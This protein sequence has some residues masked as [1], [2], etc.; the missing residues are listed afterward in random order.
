MWLMVVV[1]MFL[2]NQVNG[3]N[4]IGIST[5]SNQINEPDKRGS[6]R[7]G[8]DLYIR[9]DFA[10]GDPNVYTVLVGGKPCQIVHF[11]SD[12]SSIHCKVPESDLDFPSKS[13]IQVKSTLESITLDP[14]VSST[15]I[16]DYD[17]TP[18]ILYINPTEACPGDEISFVG[19][20]GPA[21][22]SNIKEA[23]VG[24]QLV[25]I[26]DGTEKLSFWE[27]HNVSAV[28]NDNVHGDKNAS[29]VLD[30][31]YGL[32]ATVWTGYQYDLE[33]EKYNFRTSAKIDKVSHNEGSVAGGLEISIGGAGFVQDSGR[34]KVVVDG[35][36]C[37]VNSVTYT[38]IKCT[39][40]QNLSPSPSNSSVFPGGAGV[41]RSLWKSMAPIPTLVSTT[42]P[43]ETSTLL[44]PQIKLN[45]ADYIKTRLYGLFLPPVSGLYKFYM[46]ADDWASFYLSQDSTQEKL[47]T[48]MNYQT[49]TELKDKFSHPTLVSP[50]VSLEAGS[51][52]YYEVHHSQG[53]GGSHVELGVEMPGSGPN[54]APFIQHLR[55]GP[56]TLLREI[57]RIKIGG[58]E[59]PTGG[60]L[61]LRYGGTYLNSVV[62]DENTKGWNC[63][64]II[65]AIYK[66]VEG[67]F[68]CSMEVVENTLIYNI[69]FNYPKTRPRK[70]F[71]VEASWIVPPNLPC[72]V[73]KFPGSLPISGTY[74]ISYRGETT[75]T[76]YHIPWLK[77]VEKDLNSMFS[78]LNSKL[79]LKG[80]SGPD[81]LD[82]YLILPADLLKGRL[83]EFSI[84][85]SGLYGGGTEGALEPDDIVVR[86]EIISVPGNNVF[87]QVIPSDYLRTYHVDPQIVVSIDGRRLPCRTECR[88]T[89]KAPPEYPLI[90]SMNEDAANNELIIEGNLT[91]LMLNETLVE[92]GFENCELKSIND[93]QIVCDIPKGSSATVAVAG[94]WTP[95]LKVQDKGI[96]VAS[97]D[98]QVT[99]PLT[100]TSISPDKGSEQGGTLLT[101]TGK[102][103]LNSLSN[104]KITQTVMIGDSICNILSTS[105]TCITCKTSPMS[106]TSNLQIQLGLTSESSALFSYDSSSTPSISSISPSYASTIVK[107][108]VTISGSGFGSDKSKVS[109]TLNNDKLGSYDCLITTVSPDTINCNINGGPRGSYKLSVYIE[110][111]GYASF[112][113]ISSTFDLV[114]KIT[115]I[116]P[117]S[118][119]L[120]GGTLLTIQGQGFSSEKFFM[121]AFIGSQENKCSIQTSSSTSFTCLTSDS[122]SEDPSEDFEFILYGR[123]TDRATCE[124]TGGDCLFKWSQEATPVVTGA[125]STS[126]KAGDSVFISGNGFGSDLNAVKVWFADEEASVLSAS[127]VEIKVTV[128]YVLGTSLP[129]KVSVDGKGLA[130]CSVV[131]TNNIYVQEVTPKEVSKAGAIV[132]IRGSG[133]YENIKANF[134]GVDCAV[135]HVTD[136]EVTC[137]VQGYSYDENLKN[138]ALGSYTCTNSAV[139]AISFKTSK[140]FA[141]TGQSGNLIIAGSFPASA[142]SSDAEVKLVSSQSEY[143][144]TVSALTSTSLSCTPQAPAGNYTLS[145]HLANYGF[146]TGSGSLAYRLSLSATTFTS[147]SSSYAG[148]PTLTI[149]GFG[150]H[151]SSTVKVCG[152]ICPIESTTGSS[153]KCTLPA[154]FTSYSITTYGLKSSGKLD[155]FTIISSSSA[156][157][158]K[159]FD[160]DISTYFKD[161]TNA[162]SYIGIDAE[163]GWKFR[164]DKVKFIGGGVNQGAYKDLVG[165]ILQGSDTGTTWTDVKK[166]VTINNFWNSWAS[167]SGSEAKFRFFR[168]FKAAAS[169]SWLINDVEFY[170]LRFK[171]SNDAKQTCTVLVYSD[172]KASPVTPTGTVYYLP[173]FTGMVTSLSPN[174]GTSAGGTEIK[175]VGTGFGTKAA[176]VSVLIDK[177]TCQLVSVSNV[178]IVCTT[179]ARPEYTEKSFEVLIKDKGRASTQGILFTYAE[180]WSD[181]N[182]WG[183]EVPPRAGETVYVPA[184]MN[185]LIDQATPLLQAILVE[186]ALIV[187]DVPGITIDSYYIFVNGGL[188]QIGT[189]EKPFENEITVTIHGN[190]DSPTLPSYGNKFI[191][192]RNGVLDIHGDPRTP[193]WSI[194]QETAKAGDSLIKLQ[195]EV[196][197]KKGESIVLATTSYSL[198]ESET[199]VIDH[200]DSISPNIIYLTQPLKYSH[201]AK[202]E[203]YGSD[204]IEIRGEV[205][206]LSRNIKIRG[207]D[208]GLTEQHGVHIML[209]SPGDESVIGRVEN[210]ELFNAGQAFTLGRYPLHFHMIGSV[211]SSYIRNNSIHHT[212]NR[213][214]TVHGVFYL[215]LKDNFAFHTMGHTYFIEDGIE[216]QNTI[217]HNLG[218]N[219]YQS[220]SLLNFDQTP[221]VF[222]ITNPSNYILNNHAAGGM[223]YGFWYSM[224]LHPTGP[225]ATSYVWPE[226]MELG[227]FEDNTAHSM[228]KYGLRIFHR[229]F[230][231]GSPGE[232]IANYSR[233]DWWNVDNKPV[234][235][236]FKRF[237]AWKCTRDGAIAEEV[238]DV[239]FV[240]FKVADNVFAGIELTYTQFTR[241]FH[242]TRVVNAMIVGNSGNS[243]GACK[244]SVGLITPQTDGLLVDGAKFFN[245]D[246]KMNAFGDASHSFNP[247]TRDHGARLTKLQKLSFTNSHRKIAWG[248][249]ATGFWEILDSSLTGQAGF[250]AAYWP[251]LINPDCTEQLDTYN[252][253]VCTGSNKI[254]RI[255]FYDLNEIEVFAYLNASI[256]RETGEAIPNK[257]ITNPDGSNSSVPLWSFIS[258]Q[259]GGKNHKLPERAW[260]VPFVT[261]YKYRVH[262]GS[263]P[264]DWKGIKFEQNTFEGSEW[265]HLNLNFTDHRESF[266]VSRGQLPLGVSTSDPDFV[267]VRL[268]T[269]KLSSL[270]ASDPSGTYYWNNETIDKS[271]EIMING[272]QANE[273]QFG[274]ITVTPYRC[275][276]S[277]CTTVSVIDDTNVEKTV[278][279][280]S[281]PKSWDSGTL[282]KVG[283]FI[284]IPSSWHMYLDIDTPVLRK[285]EINGILEF[286]PNKSA[287]LHANW[288][289]VRKGELRSGSEEKP[290]KKSVVHKVVLYGDPFD[291]SFTFNPDVQGG[292]KV[293]VVTGNISLHGYPKEPFTW[294]EQN[295]YPGDTTIFVSGVDWEVGDEITISPSGFQASEHELFTITEVT[296]PTSNYDQKLSKQ[297][298]PETDF[299]TDPD[300][301]RANSFR[302]YGKSKSTLD[303]SQQVESA[304]STGITKL[305]LNKAINF[306]HS[307]SRLTINDYL[308]DMRTEVALISRNVKITTN[309][310]GWPGSMLINDYLDELVEADPINRTGR[311]DLDHVYFD[312]CGQLDTNLA[313]LRFEAVGTK[314]S[315]VRNCVFKQPQNWAIYMNKA[316]KISL[317]N[318]LIYNVR[319]RGV[320]ATE[321]NDV[322]IMGNVI[323]NVFE[324]SYTESILDASAGFFI[325]SA[326]RPQCT[327][328]I[329]NNKVLGFDLVGFVMSG[330]ECGN[331]TM[332]SSG[333]KARSGELG[334]VFTN[335]GH[336]TCMELSNNIMHFCQ[337]GIGFKSST[338]E[339]H[340]SNFEFIEN[341]RGMGIRTGRLE[342]KSIIKAYLTDSVFI[343]KTI[344]SL[345]QDC[346]YNL[347]CKQK[348]GYIFGG[349]DVN[350]LEIRMTSKIKIPLYHPQG[351]AT[352]YGAHYVDN[353]RFMSF[354]A[355]SKCK[356]NDYA[357]SSN[358]GSPDYQLPQ[359][360]SKIKFDSVDKDN[361]VFMNNP[362]PKWINPEDCVD[363]NCTGPLNALA[364]DV[365]GSIVGGAGGYVLPNNPGV[366][367]ADICQ[368]N[369]VMNAYLCVAD[370]SDRN[371]YMMMIFE[372]LDKDKMTRTFAPINV[373]SYGK[374]F[375]S[376][377]GAGF[378]NDLAQFHDQTWDGFYTGHMRLSRFPGIVY[379]GQYY[380]ITSRGTLPNEL[381]F[382]LEVTQDLNLPIIV[383]IRYMDPI[384]VNVYIDNILVPGIKWSKGKISECTFIDP[385][386][387]NRWFHE[388]NTIQFVL[389]NQ[390]AV[391]IKKISS[392]RI[393]LELDINIADFFNNNGDIAF[394]DKFAAML[395]IAS[396]RIRIVNVKK[397]STILD[398][399]ILADEA[400]IQT[401]RQ[402]NELEKINDIFEETVVSG[403]LAGRIG[404]NILSYTSSV[405][406]IKDVSEQ[407]NEESENSDDVDQSSS[408]NENNDDSTQ[409]NDPNG[410][411]T[412]SESSV[413]K[414]FRVLAEDWMIAIFCIAIFLLIVLSGLVFYRKNSNKNVSL[415][416]MQSK[417]TSK[418]GDMREFEPKD[419]WNPNVTPNEENSR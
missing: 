146:A 131:F 226:F 334:F 314:E 105:T 284:D 260:N 23:R 388:Q 76:M 418:V 7:G 230:P 75:T 283:Q 360:F 154:L 197:W 120:N 222:W 119:S 123:L 8:T 10:S 209:F 343:G 400:I 31:G 95:I 153:L 371:K 278:K 348:F 328:T 169:G 397:G 255:G 35:S 136:N 356:R 57:Q 108:Q 34:V 141:I 5:L 217:E 240:D 204:T 336:F 20:W 118:G 14:S 225:S 49:T 245:F 212:F 282:P 211:S 238:G 24:S 332:L 83:D 311:A 121:T 317:I 191:G 379:S 16:Y 174:I 287:S 350:V 411:N 403:E 325:C 80:Y 416:S 69:T 196:N 393:N 110:P 72:I 307:G 33:G 376:E 398:I 54:K 221:A 308:V 73:T 189:E 265:L 337:E 44:T 257:T 279:F 414:N 341:I 156:D 41:S 228:A 1:S 405:D 375:I 359:F 38:E 9:A 175:I 300:W 218:V 368:L 50:Q 27:W 22:W 190:R 237:T 401:N 4:I 333:N 229:F 55:V 297:V 176:D 62:W 84:D 277:H 264:V 290:T 201:Y 21:E 353:V 361:K 324:R 168:L 344:H 419:S 242:T 389:R 372:S 253:I 58:N 96:V 269:R 93:S 380:N 276:G 346:K 292:N 88:F 251:H 125:S 299:S 85:A 64:E 161:P 395:N 206:L 142:P 223:A 391:Q 248:V 183:G 47:Q 352:T 36:D 301:L 399:Y 179:G 302:Q 298:Q 268:A 288:V 205:G 249:P 318:N 262:W 247:P 210:L 186:G 286:S 97:T 178:E 347:D 149:S 295:V 164:L 102:G 396:Y 202:T 167:K 100:I 46:S 166:F 134:A 304:S 408:N 152:S 236:E 233:A 351:E 82:M 316:K 147:T 185:L 252:S 184:G 329:T 192:V 258:M 390:L 66:L 89:Y 65:G 112:P 234:P 366:A 74:R 77:P 99:I 42:P 12:D 91:G 187:E 415:F 256:L 126:G 151:E 61:L 116:S 137:K 357:I 59:L 272:V 68:M 107:T 18:W 367:K 103:F 235:A 13:Q 159:A 330:G 139:C 273:N 94:T 320:V 127:D 216:S 254:R 90:T 30:G 207:S 104:S 56:S 410:G 113:S 275:F 101:I 362:D 155:Y 215:T 392:V 306:Y 370:T 382:R 381:E 128:P 173:S 145:V 364:F 280:W 291:D 87:H 345:C 417:F 239:R 15:F 213:A 271:F 319:W 335:N 331:P 369:S 180:R 402:N 263:S 193:S 52:Y 214:A 163:T 383:A 355:N 406:R 81:G 270:E 294:L 289:F 231:S 195:D 309:S 266:I 281:D 349:S 326:F 412:G 143:S 144:C 3:A 194:L 92:I 246:E 86:S 224:D 28:I 385:H 373:T 78:S 29:I 342:D 413:S 114:L 129:V 305:K 122:G 45:E 296:S 358:D 312:Q 407:S 150:L 386:G 26:L 378:R 232:P 32:G 303:P 115:S 11:D 274:D 321:I 40:S 208:E 363:W 199:A 51:A 171:N 132:Y 241:W 63:W 338:F 384:A 250:V 106:T 138:L 220:F 133:F 2:L 109:V 124:M 67:N 340:L 48:L 60:R 25:T 322:N 19:R 200:V 53:T 98:T 172:L 170:G 70:L 409:E 39:T 148:G 188:L 310:N 130:S 339:Y 315:I 181:E 37:I 243:E 365:D 354:N 313:C 285:V 135:L 160:S 162:D 79:F 374:S 182:T 165:T 6:Y 198:D 227:Q 404:Y 259:K 157:K 261:G 219:T 111:Q 394:L 17:R 293:I 327:F 158:E 177:I 267:D 244:G 323:I 377:M 203:S 71:S 140:T 387:T 117:L 43:L